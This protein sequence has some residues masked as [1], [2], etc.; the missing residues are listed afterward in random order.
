MRSSRLRQLAMLASMPSRAA[1]SSWICSEVALY[2]ATSAVS[3]QSSRRRQPWRSERKWGLAACMS[4]MN[5]SGRGSGG[6]VV[7]GVVGQG[8]EGVCIDIFPDSHSSFCKGG[9]SG[10]DADVSCDR[11]ASP[12]GDDEVGESAIVL[13][14][15]AG[16]VVLARD[17]GGRGSLLA[18]PGDLLLKVADHVLIG[19]GPGDEGS[20]GSLRDVAKGFGAPSS[21]KGL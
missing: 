13:D 2:R 20:G 7:V 6:V 21:P 9:V 12:A 3:P 5:H 14:E 15:V 16:L 8:G 17:D 10:G 18:E 19:G 11:S 1:W 4:S